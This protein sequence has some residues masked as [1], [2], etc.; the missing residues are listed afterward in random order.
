MSSKT[1]VLTELAPL[2][3]PTRCGHP[4]IVQQETLHRDGKHW[5]GELRCAG[6]HHVID[7]RR[8]QDTREHPYAAGLDVPLL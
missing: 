2:Q 6:G 7:L 8:L 1:I 3:C 4:L 5:T